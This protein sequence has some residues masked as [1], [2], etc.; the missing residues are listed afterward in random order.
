MIDTIKFKIV[1]SEDIRKRIE[2]I[3]ITTSRKDNKTNTWDFNYHNATI[4]LPSY[5]SSVNLF[6]DK[7]GLNLF[8]EF[9]LPKQI[10]GNNIF[11][12][13]PSQ[14]LDY[15]KS[16]Q[17]EL[18]NRFGD[19]PYFMTW[20]I[21]RLDLFYAWKFESQKQAEF[22]L[23][24]LKI[25]EYPRKNKQV[26]QTSINF[27]GR[28]YSVKFYLKQPEFFKHDFKNIKEKNIDLAYELYDYSS[29]ILRFEVTCRHQQL[30]QMFGSRKLYF[31]DV[32]NENELCF[33]LNNYLKRILKSA[34]Q[35]SMVETEIMDRL[36]SVYKNGKAGRLYLFYKQF[37]SSEVTRKIITSTLSYTTIWRNLNDLK[38]A[39]IGF[40][41]EVIPFNFDLSIPSNYA[42][43]YEQIDK[44]SL[45]GLVYCHS[46]SKVKGLSL[47]RNQA[48]S[49]LEEGETMFP[50]SYNK[51]NQPVIGNDH[52]AQDS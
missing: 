25:L 32:L 4:N 43:N 31:K 33:F 24:H 44:D 50:P 1:I 13:Y 19:F 41:Q 37:N 14:S 29:G 2:Q 42:V 34:S 7:T 38:K 3:S 27:S 10:F 40:D 30:N 6:I 23:D 49:L 46:G 47:D 9:S 52:G 5:D 8:V 39:N 36:K 45:L 16:L 21:I 22:I 35:T 20:Q 11:L 17:I 26:Y 51:L 18:K 15:L 12:L 48:L 28:Q